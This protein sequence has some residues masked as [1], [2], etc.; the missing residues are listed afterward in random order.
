MDE[1]EDRGWDDDKLLKLIRLKE[2]E[3]KYVNKYVA[4]Q[5]DDE[6]QLLIIKE[7]ISGKSL[8]ELRQLFGKF[9]KN[10]REIARKAFLGLA[11]LNSNNILHLNLKLSNIFQLDNGDIQLTDINFWPLDATNLKSKYLSQY[12]APELFLMGK[13][14]LVSDIWSLGYIILQLYTGL[15]PWSKITNQGKVNPM[16]NREIKICIK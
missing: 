2:E 6:D 3:T 9:Q 8:C 12:S 11:I 1:I 16:S 15:Q 7:Y 5:V 13:P 4:I 10:I 14:S